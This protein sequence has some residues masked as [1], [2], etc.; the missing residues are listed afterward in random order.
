MIKGMVSCVV[1][2]VL[3]GCSYSYQEEGSFFHRQGPSISIDKIESDVNTTMQRSLAK[4]LASNAYY[5]YTPSGGR[6][7]L[8][9]KRLEEDHERIG[10]RYDRDNAKGTL[11][12]NLLGVEDR[13]FIVVE[14]SLL[15]SYSQKVISGPHKVSASVDYDYTDPGSPR[16]L[17]FAKREPVMQF[18]L[19]QLDSYEGAY[20]SST[21]ILYR[22][23]A[24]K[25]VA[26]LNRIQ[27]DI[28][29]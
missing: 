14:V 5:R 29:S 10:F 19:G 11:E 25:I 3:A 7:T 9:V 8:K 12:K 28:S 22:N 15:D 17:I 13:H 2:L 21:P 4:E 16:D 23:L 1:M 24:K 20:D 18:S 27:P 26:G 6:Y